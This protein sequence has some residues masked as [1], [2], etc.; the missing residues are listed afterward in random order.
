MLQSWVILNWLDEQAECYNRQAEASP[1]ELNEL[2]LDDEDD[3]EENDHEDEQD[4]TSRPVSWIIEHPTVERLDL[5]LTLVFEYIDSLATHEEG[6][7]SQLRSFY[8]DSLPVFDN[9]VFKS[10]GLTHVQF[11]WFYLASLQEKIAEDFL[12][13][14]MQKIT[15]A[16]IPT[17]F[18]QYAACYA[19]SYLARAK[20]DPVK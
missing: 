7:S 2:A 15:T 1:Q 20:F 3:D 8:Q 10:N 13:R 17:V 14:V 18:R 9:I 16:N 19:S 6:N 4:Q 11:L 12:R 5:I